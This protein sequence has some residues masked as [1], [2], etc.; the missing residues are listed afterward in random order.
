MLTDSSVKNALQAAK[1]KTSK[2]RS[3]ESGHGKGKSRVKGK[4]KRKGKCASKKL[5]ESQ[6]IDSSD[7]EDD[8]YCIIC[9]E[10]YQNSRPG[11]DWIKCQSCVNWA[12]EQCTDVGSKNF[13][14]VCHHCD[15]D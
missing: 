14:F 11:E 3:A 15:S 5:K 1:S 8:C 6:K 9:F 2:K 12:H 13:I 4:G 10:A 7:E